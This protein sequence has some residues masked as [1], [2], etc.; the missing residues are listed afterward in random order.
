MAA[1]LKKDQPYFPGNKELFPRTKIF[2]N[3][4]LLPPSLIAEA[5]ELSSGDPV[6]VTNVAPDGIITAT[7]QDGSDKI[8][9]YRWTSLGKPIGSCQDEYHRSLQNRDSLLA[10]L[11]QHFEYHFNI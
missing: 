3:T 11:T 7:F 10:A 2:W 4:S 1:K 8:A 9:A 6:T 5:Y